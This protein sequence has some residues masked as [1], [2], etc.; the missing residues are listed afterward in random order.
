MLSVEI[1]LEPL[2]VGLLPLWD[3]N[4]SLLPRYKGNVP[5]IS[6]QY[7]AFAANKA[8]R[9]HTEIGQF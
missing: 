5:E 8:N 4:P 9:L 2:P 1:V 6:F 3:K 7:E